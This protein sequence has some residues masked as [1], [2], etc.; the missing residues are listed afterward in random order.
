MSDTFSLVVVIGVLIALFLFIGA[1]WWKIRKGSGSA[2]IMLGAMHNFLNEDQQRAAEVITLQEQKKKMGE[3][4]S[5][6]PDEPEPM[7]E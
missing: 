7:P 6:E 3:Q 5:G 4:E 2:T 1:I